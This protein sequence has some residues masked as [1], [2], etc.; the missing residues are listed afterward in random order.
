MGIFFNIA[1][2]VI[3][4][5]CYLSMIVYREI[6]SRK[7]M[8]LRHILIPSGFILAFYILYTFYNGG[9]RLFSPFIYPTW[10]FMLLGYVQIY[11]ALM[12]PMFFSAVYL[13][14]RRNN[15]SAMIAPVAFTLY[16]AI[17]LRGAIFYVSYIFL[18]Y[19]VWGLVCVYTPRFVWRGYVK[20][21]NK[22]G[23][24]ILRNIM[25]GLIIITFVTVACVIVF[26]I[27]SNTGKN[28]ADYLPPHMVNPP[29]T[30]NPP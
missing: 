7:S 13:D 23:G 5:L 14:E 29:M 3:I 18:P 15:W 9:I 27:I 21:R 26:T 22:F 20:L 11:F 10:F 19:L 2:A 17:L 30:T 12:I 16:M 25:A 6:F 4:L 8:T 28:E 1:Y 24:N